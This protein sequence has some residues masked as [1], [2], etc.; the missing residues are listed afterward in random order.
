MVTS[1]ST[2]T[3][4]SKPSSMPTSSPLVRVLLL[5]FL[6]EVSGIQIESFFLLDLDGS[7]HVDEPDVVSPSAKGSGKFF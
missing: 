4:L 6:F 2:V 1:S 3:S 5:H 7:V